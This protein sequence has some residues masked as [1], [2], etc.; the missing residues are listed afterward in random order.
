M[1]NSS[2]TGSAQIQ[3]LA[4][5]STSAQYGTANVAG[6]Y[7]SISQ[8]APTLMTETPLNYIPI[9]PCRAVDTRNPAGPFGA[10]YVTG[11][12]SRSFA[13]PSSSCNIP[14]NAA[15][16][17]MNVTVVPHDVLGYLTAWPSGQVQPYVSTVN[18]MDGRIKANAAILPAGTNGAVSFFATNDTEVVIDIN[19]YFVA[20]SSNTGLNFFTLAPCRIV[21]TRTSVNTFGTPS[22]APYLERDFPILQSNCGVPAEAKAYSLNVTAVPQ[23]P[24]SFITMWPAGQ[25]QPLVSTLN[26]PTGSITANAALLSAG[27]GGDLAVMA[28]N[29]SDLVL[30]INGYFAPP[31]A[32]GLHFYAVPPCRLLD[33]R[34][35]VN[36]PSLGE[37]SI[38]VAGAC[39]VPS[40]ASALV[41]NATVV[42]PAPLSYLTLWPDGETQPFVSTLNSPD[43][44]VASNMA[45]VP[46]NNGAID[47][48]FTN[49]SYLVIDV[50]GYFAP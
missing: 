8:Q 22:L 41:I 34:L 7:V 1:G 5:A 40:N 48:F 26:A 13:M 37:Q 18:S 50:N 6:N 29:L 27:A 46:L 2:G 17:A 19:G 39:N 42:P 47:S 11:M 4:S 36:T 12:T 49:A 16:Y 35:S 44:M 32:S 10:P 21:D 45:I 3:F 43:G 20:A 33:T 23:V 38:S 28:T 31:A 24:L 25:N 14:S 30:D 9:T 15:A